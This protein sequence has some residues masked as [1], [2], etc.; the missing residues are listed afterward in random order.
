MQGKCYHKQR[1]LRMRYSASGFP[2]TSGE[3]LAL[4]ARLDSEEPCV[5]GHTPARGG[6]AARRA[7]AKF[8]SLLKNAGGVQTEVIKKMS[9][10]TKVVSWFGVHAT[11]PRATHL[12]IA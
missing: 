6:N 10:G 12:F 11:V 3:P 2:I 1:P 7:L 4:S 9:K 8:P 5:R